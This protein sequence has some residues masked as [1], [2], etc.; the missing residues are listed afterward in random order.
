MNGP[1]L[2]VHQPLRSSTASTIAGGRTA[3]PESYTRRS[4]RRRRGPAP[5]ETIDLTSTQAPQNLTGPPAAKRARTNAF[6]TPHRSSATPLVSTTSSDQKPAPRF[7]GDPIEEID[8]TEAGSNNKL[9]AKAR[10][11][12][13]KMQKV[14][15]PEKPKL[16]DFKCVICLDDPTDLA[17]TP[18]G[19]YKLLEPLLQKAGTDGAI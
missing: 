19:K 5:S 9:L 3:S 8:L 17:A 7:L 11:D 13:L 15:G 12:L 6:Q 10:E 1:S 18:C 16:A 14:D 4:T 2:E